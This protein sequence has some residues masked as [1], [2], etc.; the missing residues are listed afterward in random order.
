[1]AI[2]IAIVAICSI[3]ACGGSSTSTKQP[4]NYT[5]TFTATT[6]STKQTINF[7]LTVNCTAK[8]LS[9]VKFTG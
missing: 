3:A 6:A 5:V 9:L 4:P 2:V 1:M 7:T 8:Q